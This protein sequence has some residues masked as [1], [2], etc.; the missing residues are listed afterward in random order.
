M[1]DLLNTTKYFL[2]V[3]TTSFLI[4]CGGGGSDGGSDNDLPTPPPPAADEGSQVDINTLAANTFIT[5]NI[6]ITANPQTLTFGTTQKGKSK[7]LS[8]TINNNT[9]QNIKLH[10]NLNSVTS[11]FSIVSN[12]EIGLTP[13]RPLEVSRGA[14]KEISVRANAEVAGIYT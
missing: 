14:S 8:F 3:L 13:Q 11:A 7:S 10:F 6:R 4:H 5:N 9:Q 12:P 2:L 1:K